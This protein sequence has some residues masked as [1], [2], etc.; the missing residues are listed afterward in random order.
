MYGVVRT[1][2]VGSVLMYMPSVAEV[3]ATGPAITY[4]RFGCTRAKKK[5]RSKRG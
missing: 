1:E 2:R 4:D 3:A 5:P